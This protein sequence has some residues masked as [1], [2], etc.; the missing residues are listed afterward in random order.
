MIAHIPTKILYVCRKPTSV[1]IGWE[2]FDD[3]RTVSVVPAYPVDPDG[4]KKTVQNAI[5]WARGRY[6]HDGEAPATKETANAPVDHV[7]I[8]NLEIRGEG[9]RAYKVVVGDG[10]Y[11]DLREDVFLDAL[12]TN[13]VGVGGLLRGPFVWAKVGAQMKLVRVGSD[14]YDRVV[15]A[16]EHGAKKNVRTSNIEVGG[17]YK[18]RVGAV[19]VYLGQCNSTVVT[20]EHT[21][22]NYEDFTNMQGW[23]ELSTS[24]PPNRENFDDQI[25]HN[26]WFYFTGVKKKTVVEKLGDIELP[27]N[28]WA[29]IRQMVRDS[30]KKIVEHST[31]GPLKDSADYLQYKKERELI[32]GSRALYVRGVDEPWF[33]GIVPVGKILNGDPT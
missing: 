17:V 33:K 12:L 18:N 14:L 1:Q 28:V 31:S 8:V 7:Q 22:Y 24:S 10:V 5:D 2:D 3:A 4:N 27:V 6:V 23:F 25:R 13:G 20:K 29:A 9:G 30:V 21:W 11:V 16:H 26:A 32:E 19:F 15:V